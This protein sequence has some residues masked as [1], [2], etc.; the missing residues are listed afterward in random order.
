MHPSPKV[1]L[2][3]FLLL[4]LV[5]ITKSYID[6]DCEI[7]SSSS[8][9]AFNLPLTIGNGKYPIALSLENK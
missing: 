7:T 4:A 2:Q 8:D 3:T 1:I 6:I 5:E 9:I